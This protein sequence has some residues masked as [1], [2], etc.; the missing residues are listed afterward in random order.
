[1]Q[2]G[3]WQATPGFRGSLIALG[4]PDRPAHGAPTSTPAMPPATT[5]RAASAAGWWIAGGAI[6]GVLLLGI[7][8]V[9]LAAAFLRNG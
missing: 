2:A 1:V 7:G 9:L 8:T 6:T 5:S 4:L 3:W